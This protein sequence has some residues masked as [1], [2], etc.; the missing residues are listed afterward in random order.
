MNALRKARL[1][2]LE[3]A[4]IAAEGALKNSRCASAS[5]IENYFA[6]GGIGSFPGVDSMGLARLQ[7]EALEARATF[8]AAQFTGR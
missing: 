8:R 3:H 1:E 5:Q 7:E 6:S 2:E 4:A